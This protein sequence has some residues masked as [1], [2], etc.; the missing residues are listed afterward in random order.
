M[1]NY[2]PMLAVTLILGNACVCLAQQRSGFQPYTPTVVGG[3]PPSSKGLEQPVFVADRTLEPSLSSESDLDAVPT[4]QQQMTLFEAGMLVAAVGEERVTVGDLIPADKLTSK[5][6]ANPQ[7][8]MML[9]KELVEAVTR[10]ALA[11]RF[12]NDKVSGK[13]PKERAQARKQIETQ[14]RKIFH[15]KWVPMQ[16]EKMKIESTL[17]FEEK[18]A[19]AGKTLESMKRD[20]AESTWAQEHI[21]E[22]VKENPV[23]NLFELQDY[24]ND[25]LDTFK[26]PARAR[27]QMLSA[28]FD[29]YPN[30]Q[31]ADQ[32]I[33]EM[34]DEVYFGGA[35]FEA[36]AKRKSTDFKA[37]EGGQFDWTTQGALKSTVID[38]AIFE[39]PLRRLSEILTDEDGYHIV[40]VLERQPA[41][42]QSFAEAQ[43]EIRKLLTK[44]TS[45]KLRTEF[46]KKVR[47]E[48][49][50]FTKWP[51]DIPGSKDLSLLTQ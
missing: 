44:Q 38:K 37:S 3:L 25:H 48:T 18:L 51:E 10:K 49:P 7:F 1:K 8:E 29:K 31:A 21:R 24:Y 5:M 16:M 35:P 9:R 15:E 13:P 28:I 26:R 27:F 46:M 22:N 12:V 45:T 17:E 41:S 33:R 43:A 23:L 19:T 47:A 36:V 34:G 32:A 4:T 50:V 14:T 6:M 39:N 11:Q 40:E 20:F 42:V 30:K 2:V